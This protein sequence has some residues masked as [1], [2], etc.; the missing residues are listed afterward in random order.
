[1]T[2]PVRRHILILDPERDT[3][4]LFARALEAR[5]DCKCYLAAT[6]E[7][8]VDLLKDISF[9]IVL[10]D[11]GTVTKS[12]FGLLRKVR[13]SFPALFILIDA[14]LHQRDLVNRALAAGAHGYII[15][16]IKIDSFRK[17]IDELTTSPNRHHCEQ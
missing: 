11:V 4:E 15:K 16:P 8:A 12:D 14:Y 9:D 13:R 1:M 5:R 17:K 10:M 3:G 6:E 2:D 7:E